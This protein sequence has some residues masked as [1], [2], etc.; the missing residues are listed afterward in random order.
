[1]G[2]ETVKKVFVTKQKATNVQLD[3]YQQT[4]DVNMD[5]N[6][7]PSTPSVSRFELY[8]R[9]QRERKNAMQQAESGE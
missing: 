3:P 8:K 1:M 5:N 2:D 6:S 4:A 7:W 9:K